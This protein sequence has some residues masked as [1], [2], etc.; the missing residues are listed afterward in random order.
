LLEADEPVAAAA[1][2]LAAE[3]VVVVVVIAGVVLT[4]VPGVTTTAVVADGSEVAG[5]E[6]ALVVEIAPGVTVFSPQAASAR[7]KLIHRTKKRVN[8]TTCCFRIT[9]SFRK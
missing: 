5:T 4:A 9:Y 2:V 3:V 6:V 7:D 8:Q 1:V